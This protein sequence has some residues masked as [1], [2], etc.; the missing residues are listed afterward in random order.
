MSRA[1]VLDI[2]KEN[3]QASASVIARRLG[4]SRQAVH[5][6]LNVLLESGEIIKVGEAPKALYKLA[7]DTPGS[8]Y[9]VRQNYSVTKQDRRAKNAQKSCVVWFTGFSGSG[10]S[11]LH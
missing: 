5:K 4:I 7:A 11:T 10:K 6:Q 2:I 9:I 3:K 1:A 8:N